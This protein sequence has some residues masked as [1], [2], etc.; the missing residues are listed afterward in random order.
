MR[1]LALLVLTACAATPS[2]PSADP[3]SAALLGFFA[4]AWDTVMDTV[5]PNRTRAELEPLDDDD[6]ALLKDWLDLGDVDDARLNRALLQSFDEGKRLVDILAPQVQALR[7]RQEVAGLLERDGRRVLGQ[8]AETVH[9]G[10]SLVIPYTSLLAWAEETPDTSTLTNLGATL[11]AFEIRA[12][13]RG[14]EDFAHHV[15]VAGSVLDV[16]VFTASYWETL[17]F[18]DDCFLGQQVHTYLFASGAYDRGAGEVTAPWSTALDDRIYNDWPVTDEGYL[19][20]TDPVCRAPVDPAVTADAVRD[21]QQLAWDA[22]WV[23]REA[24]PE[25]E[26]LRVLVRNVLDSAVPFEPAR[27]APDDAVP[28]PAIAFDLAWTGGDPDGDPVRYDV[29]VDGVRVAQNQRATRWS[30]TVD[31]GQ[32]HTWQVTA[33][34]AWGKERRGPLW[35]F[36]TLDATA[37]FADADHDL[38]TIADGDCDDHDPTVFPDNTETWYD[39]RDDNCDPSDDDDADGDHVDA[40]IVGGADC[41]D[42]DADI[43]PFADEQCT[44]GVDEDCDGRVDCADDACIAE[45]V[46]I[47]ATLHDDDGDGWRPVDGDCDDADGDVYPGQTE[48]VTNGRDDDCDGWVDEP[49]VTVTRGAYLDD[50]EPYGV[51][52]VRDDGTIAALLYDRDHLGEVALWLDLEGSPRRVA[53]PNAP[54]RA[55]SLTTDGQAWFVACVRDG[56]PSDVFV[57]RYD[58][59]GWAW[60]DLVP[61]QVDGLSLVDALWLEGT[62]LTVIAGRRSTQSALEIVLQRVGTTWTTTVRNGGGTGGPFAPTTSPDS[63]WQLRP[64]T[65][66]RLDRVAWNGTTWVPTT[67]TLPWDLDSGTVRELPEGVMVVGRSNGAILAGLRVAPGSWTTTSPTFSDGRLVVAEDAALLDPSTWCFWASASGVGAVKHVTCVNQGVPTDLWTAPVDGL[68][69]RFTPLADGTFLHLGIDLGQARLDRMDPTVGATASTDVATNRPV[70]GVAIGASATPPVWMETQ[71][72]GLRTLTA[73]RGA[74]LEDIDADLRVLPGSIAVDDTGAVAFAAVHVDGTAAA[75][76]YG[77]V[78]PG[79]SLP[80]LADLDELGRVSWFS[81]RNTLDVD[82]EVHGDDTWAAVWQ[83]GNHTGA[84]VSGTSVAAYHHDGA[85]WSAFAVA[86]GPSGGSR[87]TTGVE[88]AI[89]PAGQAYLAYSEGDWVR[90]ATLTTAGPTVVQT[91]FDAEVALLEADDDDLILLHHDLAGP[92]DLLLRWSPGIGVTATADLGV[93]FDAA[94]MEVVGGVTHVFGQTDAGAWV[95]LR[96]TPELGFETSAL[97]LDV[98]TADAVDLAWDG[99]RLQAVVADRDGVW[100]IGL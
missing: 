98:D 15:D 88:V 24:S 57:G 33:R 82:L 18:A 95:H 22:M 65:P 53:L 29:D 91:L 56:S 66:A 71:R 59:A 97:P 58:A 1:P 63:F 20:S 72:N 31:W 80:A 38:W 23:T 9:E 39:G 73:D 50:G 44:G 55:C 35:T 17:R 84:T 27:V 41:D 25:R 3:G 64:G 60:W 13:L 21:F 90:L 36:Q 92:N 7:T 43:S 10:A 14:M 46:C 89:T 4:G 85:G 30:V 62:G 67:E 51:P 75:F 19:L 83:K 70:T 47:P 99:A 42:H 61:T 26:T 11:D 100:R 48:D 69:S 37:A 16:A 45:L 86:A 94:A 40:A 32:T 2:A 74:A 68:W 81:S 87:E 34:D 77:H 5:F 8:M 76:V 96:G 28:V 79:A 12:T 6:L 49:P 78:A 52:V 93:T 54:Q